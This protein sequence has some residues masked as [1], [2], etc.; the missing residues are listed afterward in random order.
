MRFQSFFCTLAACLCACG[1]P[2]P[3]TQPVQEQVLDRSTLQNDLE[4][5][6]IPARGETVAVQLWL[7]F[8]SSD[9]P[10]NQP[11]TSE[12]V[13]EALLGR[14]RSEGLAP[15]LEQLGARLQSYVTFDRAVIEVEVLPSDLKDTL[16]ELAKAVVSPDLSADWAPV[17]KRLAARPGPS[18]RRV[19]LE[20]I[21]SEAFGE[22]PAH[23]R[24]EAALTLSDNSL[25][26]FA[27]KYVVP[28][29]SVLLVAGTVDRDTIQHAFREWTGK[30]PNA[31][32]R[33]KSKG[34]SFSSNQQ[35]P[36]VRIE[37]STAQRAQLRFAFPMGEL[38]PREAAQAD[39][40]AI[41]LGY[42]EN[43]RIR[44]AAEA[45]GIHLD[46]LRAFAYAPKRH[47]LFVLE[48][49]CAGDELDRVYLLV[50][51][52]LYN[53][54]NSPATRLALDQ[55]RRT[56]LDD[57]RQ[58]ASTPTGRARREASFVTRWNAK[59]ENEYN[60]ELSAV[61]AHELRT[62]AGLI[63][64]PQRTI[65]LLE[66]PAAFATLDTE[67]WSET[68]AE[69]A[70][71]FANDEK[72][73]DKHNLRLGESARARIYTQTSGATTGVVAILASGSSL[74]TNENGGLSELV[75][76]RLAENGFNAKVTRDQIILSRNGTTEE[77]DEI[78]TVLGRDLAQA[79]FG[80]HEIESARARARQ[81]RE[82]QSTRALAQSEFEARIFHLPRH[83]D[84][85]E[86]LTPAEVR[87]WYDAAIA[88][89]R[90]E[91]TL[92]GDISPRRVE[93]ALSPIFTR[94]TPISTADTVQ[95][96]ENAEESQE[97][98]AVTATTKRVI[99]GTT[100]HMIVGYPVEMTGELDIASAEVLTAWLLDERM[101]GLNYIRSQFANAPLRVA[102]ILDLNPQGY[103]A[104]Y[105]EGQREVVDAA[106]HSLRAAKRKLAAVQPGIADLRDIRRRLQSHRTI[107]LQNPLQRA[108]FFAE[109]AWNDRRFSDPDGLEVWRNTVERVTPQA[110]SSFAK[111][112]DDSKRVEVVI[113]PSEENAP[114]KLKP[115][116][117]IPLSRNFTE[118]R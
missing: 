108:L 88:Q 115:T 4:I 77:L 43:A 84:R 30:R 83:Q 104:F 75:A 101:S 15:Q 28:E 76:W 59:A 7:P 21:W 109:H 68:L 86:T 13:L 18:A 116:E 98:E 25:E 22:A 63:F 85:L 90:L 49:E 102:P 64:T 110:L 100:T 97:S 14:D 99:D 6:T 37:T 9:D 89:A 69:K 44:R 12:A 114:P 56:L 3:Q 19:G 57:A 52:A 11:G 80:P 48:V 29:G 55:S 16:N 41:T 91:I 111:N 106:V 45:Q 51:D 61:T 95:P 62:A 58:A 113:G 10:P 34:F 107:A 32:N 36:Q 78:L 105:I 74:E 39:L 31:A 66:V 17:R 82:R 79:S 92:V 27:Q 87:A 20:A 81:Q 103:V 70:R 2:A 46:R 60:K 33:A 65:A 94:R 67:L 71:N 93:R 24:S 54:Q 112:L 50:L 1:G 73:L 23:T 42:G 117:N 40:I 5:L 96:P 47:G 26:R 35:E 38:S 53:F 8:G 72:K 118:S